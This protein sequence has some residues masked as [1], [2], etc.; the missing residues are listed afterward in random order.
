MPEW[1]SLVEV[2]ERTFN[3][4]RNSPPTGDLRED[5]LREEPE[6]EVFRAYS[7]HRA[8]IEGLL[9]GRDYLKGALRYH[10]VFAGAVHDFFDRVFVNVDEPV[11]RNN[12]LLL[13]QA[14]HSL[15]AKN[16]ANLVQVVMPG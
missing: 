3:I 7:Q 16:L 6:I 12:R 1:P 10:E 14:V 11:L 8:E 5:L 9:S 4:F 13:M 2:V 15:F